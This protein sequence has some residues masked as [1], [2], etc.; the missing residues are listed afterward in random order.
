VSL[1][2]H[3]TDLSNESKRINQLVNA[4]TFNSKARLDEDPATSRRLGSFNHD[5]E[6]GLYPKKWASLAGKQPLE[7]EA[8]FID[9]PK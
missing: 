1:R 9:V 7:P 8:T 6:I 3:P 4:L 5:Y 2:R